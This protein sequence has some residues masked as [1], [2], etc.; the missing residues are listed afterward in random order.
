MASVQLHHVNFCSSDVPRLEEFYR[1]VLGLEALG[2]APAGASRILSDSGYSAR[3]A[4]LRSNGIEMHLA[5]TDLNLGFRRNQA[6]NPLVTGHLAF[7]TD[8]LGQLKA[9]LEAA[10]VPYSDYGVWSIEGWHQIFFMDP[11]GN[12]VEVHQVVGR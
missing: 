2:D 4:F 7:R 1:G 5:T 11:A 3:V 12:I 6:L 10:G 9:R 8:D